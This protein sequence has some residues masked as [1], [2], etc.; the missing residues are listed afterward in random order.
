MSK[1]NFDT[2]YCTSLTCKNKCWRHTS[3]FEFE[4]DKNY[5]F[6]EKC[7]NSGYSVNIPIEKKEKKV[8]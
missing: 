5:W 1:A 2:T 7:I 3:N 8:L 6:Q 4:N